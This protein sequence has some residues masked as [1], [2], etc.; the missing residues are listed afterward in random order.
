MRE[1]KRLKLTNPTAIRKALN[2]VANMVLNGEIDPK[3]AN[4]II[5]GANIIL[6]S[7]KMGVPEKVDSVNIVIDIPDNRI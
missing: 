2:S 7:L 5:Y 3:Q 1:G 4:V 6:S